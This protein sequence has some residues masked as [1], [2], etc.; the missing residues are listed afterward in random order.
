MVLVSGIGSVTK[1]PLAGGVWCAGGSF[2][3]AGL[4]YEYEGE[5]YQNTG[6]MD[7]AP[8]AAALAWR[9]KVRL[10]VEANPSP[11]QNCWWKF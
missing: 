7:Y 6:T 5:M 3:E 4:E 1:T 2:L 11:A 8:S 9:Q 10:Q